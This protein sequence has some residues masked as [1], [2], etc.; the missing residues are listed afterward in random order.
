MR[1]YAAPP[2]R[3]PVRRCAWCNDDSSDHAIGEFEEHQ[4]LLEANTDEPAVRRHTAAAKL[5]RAR[6]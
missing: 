4:I 2:R 5:E 6:R 3:H 1:I